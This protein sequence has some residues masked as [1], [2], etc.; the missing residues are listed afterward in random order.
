MAP[1]FLRRLLDL[2][3]S[4]DIAPAKPWNFAF[5]ILVGLTMDASFVLELFSSNSAIGWVRFAVALGFLAMTLPL[6][7]SNILITALRMSLASLAAGLGL[8]ALLPAYCIPAMHV[9]FIG[10]STVG[11][12]S[13]GTRVVLGHS[14]NL[15]LLRARPCFFLVTLLLLI[16]AMISRFMAA[17][18]V[19]RNEHLMGAAIAW[20]AA[21]AL[22]SV[23]VLP[24]VARSDPDR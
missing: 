20:L 14:G 22:W 17:F 4:D 10:G 24:H 7:G 11:V 6:R 13:V 9:L 16:L 5:A 2:P 18:V 8:M 21:A 19:T 23:F 12:F 15:H 1:F 3:S